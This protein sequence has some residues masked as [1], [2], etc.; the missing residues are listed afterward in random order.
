LLSGLEAALLSYLREFFSAKSDVV[1]PI[2]LVGQALFTLRFLVQWLA[3][4]RAGRSI[5]PRSF[6][7]LSVSGGFLL[8]IYAV[9]RRDPVFILGQLFGLLVY[10]RN[11]NF[12]LR[13]AR[14]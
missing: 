2:G 7:F 14:E 6:W 13:N 9:C 1:L 4:E 8:L 3:S 5:V 12:V 11:I 10:I